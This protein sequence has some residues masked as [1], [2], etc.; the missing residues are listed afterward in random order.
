MIQCIQRLSRV[1]E[2]LF[3]YIIRKEILN[4]KN[5]P[6]L[7]FLNDVIKNLNIFLKKRDTTNYRSLS[8]ETKTCIRQS[9]R[10]IHT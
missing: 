6:Y 4:N 3:L 9:N 7:N 5:H 1:G 2:L 10:Y 8:I